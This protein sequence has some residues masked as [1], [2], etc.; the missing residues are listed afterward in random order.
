MNQFSELTLPASIH[1]N[2]A[3]HLFVTPTP[4]QSQAIP[5]ALA[6]SDVVATAQTGTGK[7]LAFLLPV[8]DKLL[9]NTG[10]GDPRGASAPIGALILSPT[11]ELAIQIAETFE[12]LAGG[13]GIRAAIVVGGL[14][15]QTQLNAI[16]RGAR[17]VIATPGRLEDFLN[18]RL[19]KLGAVETL[20]LD[21]ADRMLDMGFLP[22]IEKILTALPA[23]RQSLFFS[24]TM[25]KDVERLIARHSKSPVRIAVGSSTM[26]A[27]EQIDLHV[28]EVEHD[29]KLGLLRHMLS[30]ETG[31]FLVF[32]RTKHAT[33]RLAKRLT[34]YGLRA[35]AMHGNRTQNQRNQALAGFRD[36]RYRVLVATDVA[37]RGIHVDSVAHVVNYDLPQ[38]PQDFIHRVGRTGRAGQRGSAS[39]FSLR[40]ERGEIRRIERECKLRMERREV[41]P[42][43]VRE[44]REPRESESASA[45]EPERKHSSSA[46]A[47][48]FKGNKKVFPSARHNR[49]TGSGSR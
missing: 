28:Y 30:K 11:R 24:A 27:P 19:I 37:A 1:Q 31:S 7:T 20:V 34:G 23:N 35:V 29:M 42:D 49:H 26:Q 33:D 46:K 36:G 39:T 48:S 15:E 16:R 41:S 47:F 13:T 18:R 32:A 22:A 44:E 40:S 14:S 45:S 9:K 8:M 38:A 2:L 3:R 10:A 4:V 17:M 25:E 5:P 12:K 43:V 21:E 6:G